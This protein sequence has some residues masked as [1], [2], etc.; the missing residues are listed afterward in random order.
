MD[1]TLPLTTALEL[2]MSPHLASFDR[3]K[4]RKIGTV[5]VSW[6]D[7]E[8]VTRASSPSSPGADDDEVGVE[9]DPWRRHVLIGSIVG[10]EV[11]IIFGL[12][13]SLARGSTDP[14]TVRLDAGDPLGRPALSFWLRRKALPTASGC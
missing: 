4:T 1:S 2:E 11:A 5:A 13:A 9:T 12:L 10:S 6:S 14:R 8:T 3:R 7:A